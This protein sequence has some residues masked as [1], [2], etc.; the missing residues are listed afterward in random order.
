RDVR[1]LSRTAPRGDV[2]RV[3][4]AGEIPGVA[5][6]ILKANARVRVGS[7]VVHVP[8]RKM[9]DRVT[10]VGRV[11]VDRDIRRLA[12]I[13]L[14]SGIGLCLNRDGW[15][16]ERCSARYSI[17]LE[18]RAIIYAGGET[19]VRLDPNGCL[20]CEHFRGELARCRWNVVPVTYDARHV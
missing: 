3:R 7:G 16:F 10:H 20:R 19:S 6:S 2:P 17:E 8:E 13:E 5:E 18:Y 1:R 14:G 11:D 9:N 4:D 12:Q 15:I